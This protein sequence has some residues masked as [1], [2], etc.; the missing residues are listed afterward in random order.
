MWDRLL[1]AFRSIIALVFFAVGTAGLKGMDAV[2][3]LGAPFVISG[4]IV[5]GHIL[6]DVLISAVSRPPHPPWG[7]AHGSPVTR[8]R[9][10]ADSLGARRF[11]LHSK[12]RLDS[13]KVMMQ[14]LVA[15]SGIIIGLVAR[16]GSGPTALTQSGLVAFATSVFCGVIFIPALA[17]A[18]TEEDATSYKVNVF[19]YGLSLLFFNA[20]LI[21]FVLG[22]VAVVF[23]MLG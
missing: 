9:G 15:A 4:G 6:V 23:D 16:S 20:A 8:S 11:I 18:V 2:E 17:G 7:D 14:F 19:T 12:F 21:A 5:T 13:Y 10:L 1:T 3:F 22:V